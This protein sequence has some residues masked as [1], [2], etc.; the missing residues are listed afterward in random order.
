MKVFCYRNLNRKRVVWSVRDTKSGLV[1]DRVPEVILRDVTLKVS[2]AGRAR[3]LK[4]KRRNVHA[5][6][7]GKRVKETPR[8]IWKRVTYNPYKNST[9]VGWFSKSPIHSAPYAKLTQ[10]GLFVLVESK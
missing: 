8:G 10:Q 2:Q 5:G 1:V 9:F 6:I 4:N 3:V 7:E